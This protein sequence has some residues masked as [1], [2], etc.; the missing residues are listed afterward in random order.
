MIMLAAKTASSGLGRLSVWK[1]KRKAVNKKASV[2]RWQTSSIKE[3]RTKK[4][5]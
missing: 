4:E 5:D 2:G 3:I 1:H